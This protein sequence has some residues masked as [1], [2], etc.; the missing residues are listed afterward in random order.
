[1]SIRSTQKLGALCFSI[2]GGK[3]ATVEVIAD[4]ERFRKFERG[5]FELVGRAKAVQKSNRIRN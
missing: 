1:M 2:A 3:I 4:Q 5:V